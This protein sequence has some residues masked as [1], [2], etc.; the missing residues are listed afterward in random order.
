MPSRKRFGSDAVKAAHRWGE[1]NGSPDLFQMPMR[2][3]RAGMWCKVCTYG[4]VHDAVRHAH[5]IARS[6]VLVDR[7]QS[8]LEIQNMHVPYAH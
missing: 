2:R 4:H 6:S 7:F 1:Q 8:Q 3:C 5:Y